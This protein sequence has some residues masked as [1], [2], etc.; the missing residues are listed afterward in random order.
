MAVLFA[1][2][3]APSRFCGQSENS[4]LVANPRVIYIIL[5]FL[6]M[7]TATYKAASIRIRRHATGVVQR[8][9][10]S[11]S[12]STN[13]RVLIHQMGVLCAATFSKVFDLHDLRK[14]GNIYSRCCGLGEIMSLQDLRVL[15]AVAH[16]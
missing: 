4:S 15:R 7:W 11:E 8:L 16:T 6:H 10:P 3:P 5:T 9:G 2:E 1:P 12:T 13:G 14:H